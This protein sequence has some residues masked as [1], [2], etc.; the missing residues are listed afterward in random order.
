[1]VLPQRSDLSVSALAYLGDCVMELLV[2]EYLVSS[3][4]SH[5]ASLNR[6]ALEFVQ[7]SKQADAVE[8]ILPLLTDEERSFYHRG[9]NSGHLRCPK[10]TSFADY[11]K[12]TGMEVLFG[13]LHTAHRNDRAKELFTLAYFP[14][15]NPQ[16]PEE[17][18]V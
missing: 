10:N 12:A 13:F 5:S 15:S 8:R 16:N 17:T 18:E 7:A 11:R 6:A 1:M 4:L 3:G 14:E 9:R 2:R